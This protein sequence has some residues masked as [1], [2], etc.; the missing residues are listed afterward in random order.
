MILVLSNFSFFTENTGYDLQ[1]GHTPNQEFPRINDKSDHFSN[2]EPLV[3]MAIYP[4]KKERLLQAQLYV[5]RSGDT[6]ILQA[7]KM[8]ETAELAAFE[9]RLRNLEWEP[10]EY[11]LFFKRGLRF[12]GL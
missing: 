2:T 5:T 10:G 3:A 4:D 6:E 7:E 12:R 9:M 8:R 1:L 11:T